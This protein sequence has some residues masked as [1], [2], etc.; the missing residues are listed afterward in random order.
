M[1]ELSKTENQPAKIPSQTSLVPIALAVN[2]MP[3]LLTK[4]PVLIIMTLLIGNIL[5]WNRGL[6]TNHPISIASENKTETSARILPV[7]TIAIKPVSSYQVSRVYTGEVT[8]G[9]T[10]ELGF[11]RRGKLTQIL[12]E[13]GDFV[14]KNQALAYLDTGN[15]Q[16]TLRQLT[17][18]REGEV[19]KLQEMEAGPRSQT[20]GAA[21]AAVK[22][23]A[24]QLELARTK[25][26]RRQKLYEEGAISRE[27]LDEISN[28]FNVLKA[29]LEEAKNKL[30]ELLSGT[31]VERIVGQR[32]LI[33]ELDTRIADVNLNIAK[34]ILKAP[35][36]SRISVRRVDEGSVISPG[37]SILRLVE[38]ENLEV[39][40][41]LPTA[42]AYRLHQGSH[43]KLTIAD[44][45]YRAKVE[46]ILPEVDSSTRTTTVVLKLQT[47]P[48]AQ[49]AVGQIA[50]LEL[51]ET[52]RESGYWL[53]VTSLVKSV[54]GLWSCY[55]LVETPGQSNASDQ[56]KRFAVKQEDVEVL[57]V[58][59]DKMLVRGTLQ[60]N[61]LVISKGN[62]RFV[63]GQL[64]RQSK[65]SK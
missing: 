55:V 52:I 51:T 64:V 6:I 26:I 28:E 19:A 37:E 2:K 12:A 41:G 25:N 47:N 49:V 33:K 14:K 38:M 65:T 9:R 23:L 59:G 8:A 29:R 45:T 34:S 61:D 57:Y 40:I 7:E 21:H 18:Q 22:D 10:T 11:E 31:R 4:K 43:Q 30:D 13:E 53:P 20:I 39:R 44:K 1:N 58:Q 36:N 24:E 50:R 54:R 5:Y 62:H 17:F 42:T 48:Q 56:N 32:A 3:N 63:P 16:N 46:S 15:L 35:F 27:Q 60:P